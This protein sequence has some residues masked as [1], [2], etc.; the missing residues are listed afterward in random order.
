MIEN[1]I[2][3]GLAKT[4]EGL[5]Y[6]ELGDAERIELYDLTVRNLQEDLMLTIKE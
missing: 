6:V 3:W 2:K 1:A 5:Y 4:G